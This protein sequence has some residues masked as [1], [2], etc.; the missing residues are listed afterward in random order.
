VTEPYPAPADPNEAEEALVMAPSYV[1]LTQQRVRLRRAGEIFA[2]PDASGRYPI[3]VLVKQGGRFQVEAIIV[4]AAVAAGVVALPLGPILTIAGL[5]VAAGLVLAGSARAVMF[6]VP[7]GTQAV[8]AQRGRFLRVVGPGTQRVSPTVVVTHLVTTREIPFG[9]LVRAA[10]TADD[11]R[12]DTEVLFTFQIA[13]PGKFVYNTTAPDFDAVCVGAA[14]ATIREITRSVMS[15]VVLDMVGRES[16]ALQEALSSAL[17]RY[18]V[19]VTRVLVMRVEA[20]PG[21]LDSREGRR[22]AVLRTSEQEEQATLD[23]RLQADRDA[24]VRQEAQARYQRAQEEAELASAVRL[25]EIE[26]DAQAE[27][28]RLEK[29]GERLARFPEAARWDWAGERLKVARELAGNS[30]AML[31]I[32]G[33]GD[34]ADVL[35]AGALSEPVAG[36]SSGAAAEVRPAAK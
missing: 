21:F 26:L 15:E 33:N 31:N 25:R 28:L 19:R 4:A 12:V 30:R 32:G 3:V 5:V 6:T 14:Q 11:V 24:L 20:P 22:L 36:A 16:A 1:Q 2:T 29:L 10:P 18:G 34:V 23:R 7:E 35:A 17:E 27:A 13:D 9:A 8:L